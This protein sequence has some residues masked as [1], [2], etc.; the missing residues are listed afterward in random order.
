MEGGIA[1]TAPLQGLE[2][3]TNPLMIYK[4]VLFDR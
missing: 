3:L 2:V 1:P 4:F